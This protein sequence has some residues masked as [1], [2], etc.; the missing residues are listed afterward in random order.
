MIIDWSRMKIYVRT[1]ATDLR[2]AINGLAVIVQE[3]LSGDP[4]SGNLFLFCNRRR[5][6]LKALY[7]D[8]NG[9]LLAVKRLEKDRFAWPQ[10]EQEA[11]E[12]S[13]EQLRMLLDGVDFWNAHKRLEYSQ[14]T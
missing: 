14:M 6:H 2:K 9:F 7:C 3:E 4:F 11:R 13:G 10:G 8:R 1:G 5:S 12:I